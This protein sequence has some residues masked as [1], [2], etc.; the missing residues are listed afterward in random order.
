MPESDIL[1]FPTKSTIF[2]EGEETSE[3]Y[4]IISGK[5]KIIK[6][7]GDGRNL[8]LADLGP[9]AMI[10][11]MSLISGR[12]RSATAQIITEVQTKVVTKDIFTKSAAGVPAWAMCVAKVLIERL[13]QTN[14]I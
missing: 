5:V 10:G 4:I 6:A 13:R 1:T 3:M 9:G 7:T 14:I 12:P 8:V 11:E 2:R